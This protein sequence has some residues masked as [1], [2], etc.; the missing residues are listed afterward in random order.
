MIAELLMR[1]RRDAVGIELHGMAYR[2]GLS[3]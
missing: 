1:T 2:A 3:V